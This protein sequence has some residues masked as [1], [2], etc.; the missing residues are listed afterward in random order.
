MSHF[1]FLCFEI[2]FIEL[3]RRHFDRHAFDDFYAK[4][5]E[6]I[7][8]QGIVGEQPQ[9]PGTQVLENLSANPIFA[10]IRRKAQLF[11]GFYRI[12]ALFL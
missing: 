3:L 4:A 5:F 12:V 7:N 6:A 1:I 2:E 11:V 8:L 9:F 10:Q